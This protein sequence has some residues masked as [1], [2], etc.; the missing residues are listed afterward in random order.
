M[1]R[2]WSSG[3]FAR[4][5]LPPS[6]PS[7]AVPDGP[8]LFKALYAANNAILETLIPRKEM[9]K[10]KGI[11]KL[12]AGTIETRKAVLD[13]PWWK[14][15]EAESDGGDYEEFTG[16]NIDMDESS[17]AEDDDEDD[18]E[19]T[20]DDDEEGGDDDNDEMDDDDEEV[21]E[22]SPSPPPSPKK[23]KRKR[24]DE[25]PPAPPIKKVTFA[26]EPKKSKLSRKTDTL[27]GHPRTTKSK[28]SAI[29]SSMKKSKSR[30][31]E[32]KVANVAVKGKTASAGVAAR[33]AYD[34]AK[35]F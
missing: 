27:K 1:L 26:P 19:G 8:D 16:I 14:E 17:D 10:T 21:Q 33:E 11:V 18:E 6:N 22:T 9:R 12:T 15:N 23:Q 25:P 28:P 29:T 7:Q 20:E 24:L 3:K 4:Y 32:R 30:P 2:D 31:T 34:F 13:E 35:F 5:T